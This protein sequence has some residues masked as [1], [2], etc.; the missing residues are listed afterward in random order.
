M[1]RGSFANFPFF[2]EIISDSLP[3]VERRLHESAT[4]RREILKTNIEGIMRT[5]F[6]A[7]ILVGRI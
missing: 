3:P 1:K 6:V 4:T 7:E 2:N 5:G